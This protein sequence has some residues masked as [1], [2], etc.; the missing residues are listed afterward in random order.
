MKPIG[1]LVAWLTLTPIAV[2]VAGIGGCEARKA[3]YDWHVRK[4]CEKDGGVKVF[5]SVVLTR[6]EY[7]G[8]VNQFGK[9]DIPAL[10]KAPVGTALMHDYKNEYYRESNPRVIRYELRVLRAADNKV[11]G[12]RVSYSRIGGDLLAFHPSRF[13]CPSAGSDLFALV[14]QRSKE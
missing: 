7:A 9:L 5:E 11:L 13:T 12:T 14:V 2:V 1:R 10:E 6:D 8:Y 4:M 3:Y